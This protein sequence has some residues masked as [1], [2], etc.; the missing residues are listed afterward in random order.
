MQAKFFTASL[1]QT[2]NVDYANIAPPNK[3]G[4]CPGPNIASDW[5]FPRLQLAGRTQTDL[6]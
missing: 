2:L 5:F 3:N 6:S 4:R 1:A